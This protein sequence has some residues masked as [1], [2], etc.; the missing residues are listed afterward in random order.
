M[1]AVDLRIR[2]RLAA[3][4]DQLAGLTAQRGGKGLVDLMRRVDAALAAVQVGTWGIC[5]V[6][7]GGIPVDQ[8]GGDPLLTV[9]LECLGPEQRRALERDL[10]AAARVQRTLLPAPYQRQGGWEVAHL[11]EPLGAVSGDH[12]DLIPPGHPGASLDLFVGDV[13]GKGV[14]AALLQSHLHALFRA[15][16]P[17][18]LA[19][20]DLL[21]KANDLFAEATSAARYATLAALRLHSDGR[22]ELANAGHPRPLLADGRGVRPLEGGSLPLGMFRDSTFNRRELRLGPGQ[23]LLVYTDGWTE[24]ARDEEEFGIGRAAAALRR[25]HPLPL[26]ELLAECRG[27]L[28]RFLGGAA[29]GDDLTLVAVRRLGP[30]L[31]RG[32]GSAAKP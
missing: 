1:N 6:C 5:A 4:R 15:L 17:T 2:E 26:P 7:Q 32:Q 13:S 29:R 12:V 21:G 14:A 25:H 8:L 30:V 16:S 27:E 19:L 3:H 24:G 20:A 18:G 22:L 11:W 23:T 28:D 10:E 9:C 31:L